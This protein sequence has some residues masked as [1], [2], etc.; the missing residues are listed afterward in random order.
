MFIIGFSKQ[1][2]FKKLPFI[3]G[4]VASAH[5]GN[6]INAVKIA[7][8]AFKAGADAVK[9]QIFKCQKLMSKKNP[10]YKKFKKFEI[11]QDNWVKIFKQFKIDQC[12]VAEIFDIDSLIFADKQKI[13]KIYKLPSTCLNNKEMLNFLSKV[14]KPVIIAAGGATLEEIDYA[15][16]KLKR[17]KKDIIIMAG[18]Q[19]FPT[20]I[21]DSNLNKIPLIRE[22]F[23]TEIGYADHIDSN[24]ILYSFSIPLMAY[25]LGAKVIEKHITLNRKEKGTDYY[26]SLDPDEFKQFVDFLKKSHKAFSENKWDLTNAELKYRKF[27]KT[28]A[29]A[30]TNL[31]KGHKI[32]SKDLLFKRTNK[33]GITADQFATYIGKILK[34]NKFIDEIILPKELK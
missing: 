6:H 31:F 16:K 18:F 11:S 12:L 30:K 19:N 27:N 1:M 15:F 2:K 23:K 3:I 4:E 29:V 20:K 14:N 26:S 7:K 28:F 5:E 32:K 10:L 24:Q 17:T 9:F 33:T 34:K 25:T 21:E 13:F 8:Q 22:A